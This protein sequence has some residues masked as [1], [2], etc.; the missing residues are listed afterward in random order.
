MPTKIMIGGDCHLVKLLWLHHYDKLQVTVVLDWA[1]VGVELGP[2]S[3]DRCVGLGHSVLG[4]NTRTGLMTSDLKDHPWKSPG[5]RPMSGM[6]GGWGLGMWRSRMTQ[7]ESRGKAYVQDDRM[8]GLR[9]IDLGWTVSRMMLG[10]MFC[11]RNSKLEASVINTTLGQDSNWTQQW[12]MSWS[13]T[14]L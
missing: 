5:E 13:L 9:C 7:D 1:S 4:D 2:D 12:P 8:L 6:T 3:G 11:I 14:N 10:Q